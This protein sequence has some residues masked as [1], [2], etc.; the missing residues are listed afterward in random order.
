[1]KENLIPFS[2]KKQSSGWFLSYIFAIP[3]R[4]ILWQKCNLKITV[5]C[6]VE[7]PYLRLY[8]DRSWLKAACRRQP[9]DR[10]LPL[11]TDCFNS[12][13]DLQPKVTAA[14]TAP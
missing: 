3:P 9:V 1:M 2:L 13:D 4:F 11:Q 8:E 5:Y 6:S 7:R 14:F 12:A 10:S